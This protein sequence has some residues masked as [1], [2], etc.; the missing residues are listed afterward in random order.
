MGNEI[1]EMRPK[2]IIERIQQLLKP[3]G[4]TFGYSNRGILHSIKKGSKSKPCP[5]FY[6]DK[7]GKIYMRF[8]C[9]DTILDKCIDYETNEWLAYYVYRELKN[10]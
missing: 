4:F 1:Y 10:G 5:H 3:L 7:R 9:N 2:K 8:T 6:K